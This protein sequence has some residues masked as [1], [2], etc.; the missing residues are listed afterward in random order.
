VGQALNWSVDG[1]SFRPADNS[2]RLDFTTAG[3]EDNIANVQVG[4]S[5][6][7]KSQE[8]VTYTVQFTLPGG[9]YIPKN[10]IFKITF[11]VGTILTNATF[12]TNLFNLGDFALNKNNNIL[13]VTRNG[14][15][16]A[17]IGSP[18]D[19]TFTISGVTNTTVAA[20]N[21]QITVENQTS[22]G[23]FLASGISASFAILEV[24]AVIMDLTCES[25]GQ[26]GA[27]FLRFTEPDGAAGGAYIV[28]HSATAITEG[29]W[30]SGTIV[31][32]NWIGKA[33]GVARQELATGLTPN[34]RY[35]FAIKS[36]AAVGDYESDISNSI[37]CIAPSSAPSNIDNTAPTTRFVSP[38]PGSTIKTGTILLK[39]TARDTGGSSVRRIEISLDNGTTWSEATVVG[40][41]G[42]DKL[43][44]YAI[45][46][47][48]ARTITVLAR[49]IDWT[50]NVETPTS[51][52]FTVSENGEDIIVTPPSVPV[53]ASADEIKAAITTIQ[54]Q[55]VLLIQQLIQ[56]LLAELRVML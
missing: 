2:T 50:G 9:S 14:E 27:V 26:A 48:K 47:A 53:G 46:N 18:T 4:V 35:Y 56:R 28:K 7:V 41:D 3:D 22:G 37:S 39:G 40:E 5:N 51:I 36:A 19:I 6:S 54:Q 49:S 52:T 30:N 38:V 15:G 24:P 31:P 29:D 17:Y 11:P 1:S 10:G 25:S 13:T 8:N 34:N 20:A 43:W 23:G 45:Q 16:P 12:T 32:Q 21:K 44:E 42:A 33:K 55:L